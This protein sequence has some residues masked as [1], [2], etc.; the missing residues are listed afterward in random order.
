MEKVM[1]IILTL[2]L[3]YMAVSAGTLVFN[4]ARYIT[5]KAYEPR[6][7]KEFVH[8]KEKPQPVERAATSSHAT[9]T[10]YNAGTGLRGSMM[11]AL[12]ALP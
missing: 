11:P 8:I 7:V 9:S 10:D 6:Y 1:R 3:A 5:F 2:C 12:P 4:T